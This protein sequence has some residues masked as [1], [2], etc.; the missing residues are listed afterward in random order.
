MFFADILFAK[1]SPMPTGAGMSWP[2]EWSH[3]TALLI[4]TPWIALGWPNAMS[5]ATTGRDGR[6]SVRTVLLSISVVA[7]ALGPRHPRT[8]VFARLV[9]PVLALGGVRLLLDDFRHSTP[10]TL[11]IALA[12][13]GAALVVAPK[14]MSSKVR[15][16]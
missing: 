8:A 11:F 3:P 5:L 16:T 14:I 2:D 9:Y 13:Y 12:V 1:K 15:S 4:G 6:P 7:L 10:A